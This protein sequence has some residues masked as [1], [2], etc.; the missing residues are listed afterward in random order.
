L[1]RSG[2]RGIKAFPSFFPIF[3]QRIG[4]AKKEEGENKNALFPG[5]AGE[6]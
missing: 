6:Y 1:E 3:C 2:Y 5:V 4:L